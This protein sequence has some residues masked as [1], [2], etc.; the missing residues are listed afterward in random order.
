ML[1][2]LRMT[3]CVLV[4]LSVGSSWLQSRGPKLDC[5]SPD[6]NEGE[7]NTAFKVKVCFNP[8]TI[9]RAVPWLKLSG[10]HLEANSRV[11]GATFGNKE[12][13]LTHKT[14]GCNLGHG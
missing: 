10:L 2:L 4:Y 6:Q 7:T 5:S 12:Q 9:H 8:L 14:P 1:S 13:C 3:S 11:L